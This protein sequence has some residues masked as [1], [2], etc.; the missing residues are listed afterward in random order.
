MG[1]P[2]S[3]QIHAAFTQSQ[4]TMRRLQTEVTPLVAAGYPL[5]ASGFAVLKTTKNIAVV[6]AIVQVFTALMLCL[7]TLV[8]VAI[9]VCVDTD[10][11]EEREK[12]VSAPLRDLLLWAERWWG[13]GCWV[14]RLGVLGG[15]AGGG[16]WVWRRGGGERG[17]RVGFEDDGGENEGEAEGEDDGKDGDADSD[18]A[19]E[20]A[21]EK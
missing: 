9:L 17:E 13:V 6:I 7:Q 8:L 12:W 16:V 11:R 5:I 10:L 3:K 18:G 2:Y 20:A 15:V 14:A 21:V 19:D 1:L 4:T